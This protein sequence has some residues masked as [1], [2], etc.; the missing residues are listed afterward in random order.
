LKDL[1]IKR[2]YIPYDFSETAALALEHAVFMAKLYKAELILSHI[3]EPSSIASA[4]LHPFS[5]DE[6]NKNGELAAQKL[7]EIASEILQKSGIRIKTYVEKGRIY[8]KIIEGTKEHEVDVIVMG[9]H[10]INGFEEFF[11][12]SNAFKVVSNTPCPIITVQ[13]HAKRIGFKKII[14]PIDDTTYSR[15]K[16]PF[17]SK[18]AQHY[19]SV[20]H[21][22]GLV[23]D[24][25][26]EALKKF[27]IKIEQVEEFFEQRDVRFRTEYV[28]GDNLAAL[29]MKHAEETDADLILIMTEQQP[30]IADLFL[31]T[32][33]QRIVNHSKI[34]VMCVRPTE[35]ELT[36][37]P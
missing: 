15:Q 33:A 7:D 10:G 19:D 34:P 36:I 3:V 27:T 21:I 24:Q 11:I 12:G 2:I 26:E 13:S 29:T 31:G 32:H 23:A 16:V 37:I 1:E 14:M 5:H 28:N 35:V 4:L 9:T 8:K 30:E 17:A 22:L 6:Q 20:V 18:M 25:D